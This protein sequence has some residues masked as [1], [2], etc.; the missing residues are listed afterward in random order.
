[1][2]TQTTV[3]EALAEIVTIGKRLEKKDRFIQANLTRNDTLKDPLEKDGGSFAVVAQE[4]QSYQD[5]TRRIV[6]LRAAIRKSNEVTTVTIGS[7]TLTIA[8]WLEWRREVAPLLEELLNKISAIIQAARERAVRSQATGRS[9]LSSE[10]ATATEQPPSNIVVNVNEKELA[11]QIEDLQN[12]LGTLDGQL[13][14]KN[15]T[16]V[17]EVED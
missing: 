16:V 7:D 9:F 12:I 13:S 4:L 15:A 17:I 8:D 10:V 11:K 1:M 5:L 14:L 2:T 6:K 3:T